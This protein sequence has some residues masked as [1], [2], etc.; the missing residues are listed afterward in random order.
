MTRRRVIRLWFAIA[1]SVCLA[2]PTAGQRPLDPASPEDLKTAIDS[3]GRLDYEV[4]MNA[5]RT[6][7]RAAAAMATRALMEAVSN[8]TDGYVR[9]RALVLLSGFND[10]RSRDFMEEAIGDANDRLRAVAYTYFEHNPDKTI[11][12]L[13]IKALDKEES[14]F[15]RPELTRA[16]AAYATFDAKARE[17][18]LPLAD[19]GQDFF[20]GAVIEAL[21]DY[22]AA[23]ALNT[24]QRI[25]M[26]DGPLQDDAALALGRI[27]DRR[28]LPTLAELQRT[29]PRERQPAIAAGICLLEVNCES[30]QRFVT[31]T[32]RFSTSNLG[33]QDL[34]RAS[35]TSLAALAVAGHAD[36]FTTLVDAGVPARDPARAPIALAVGTVAARNAPLALTALEGRQ[37]LDEAVLLLRDAFDMLEED[38]EEERFF[39]SVRRAYWDAPEGSQ[40]RRVCDALI[41]KLEF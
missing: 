19:R 11:A 10:P 18:I 7:R 24:I 9:Y 28:A 32:L 23:Y 13:L 3:L 12:P 17:A 34:L 36:A 25:A 22:K 27:G 30:H 38:Y 31:A 40:R 26:L 35:A 33:F 4:R 29:A 14:E 5:S 16:V 37:D 21:G 15:V 8:H 2:V 6:V 41:Q 1:A 20:R 39:V